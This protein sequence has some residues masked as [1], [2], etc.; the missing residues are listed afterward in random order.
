MRSER[1]FRIAIGAF[2]VLLV[3]TVAAGAMAVPQVEEPC[4]LDGY[5]LRLG[6]PGGHLSEAHAEVH[7][8]SYHGRGSA[9]HLRWW[10]VLTRMLGGLST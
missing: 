10:R 2:A 8:A 5:I 4:P 1:G 6:D 3:A 9:E 7:R